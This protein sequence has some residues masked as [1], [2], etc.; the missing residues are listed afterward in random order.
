MSQ[1]RRPDRV[2]DLV[3][4]GVGLIVVAMGVLWLVLCAIGWILNGR[5]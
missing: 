3:N 2:P 4:E 5:P 1:R